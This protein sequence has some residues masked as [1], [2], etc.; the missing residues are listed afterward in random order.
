MSVQLFGGGLKQVEV[1][2]GLCIASSFITLNWKNAYLYWI[3]EVYVGLR[4]K[5]VSI[6]LKKFEES[7]GMFC[8][9]IISGLQMI[10]STFGGA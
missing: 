2:L 3:Q 7:S 6:S 8:I 1:V 10:G 9:L 4:K 5:R